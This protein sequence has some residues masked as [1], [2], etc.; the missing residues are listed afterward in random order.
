M[1][2]LTLA[3]TIQRLCYARLR[4]SSEK[5]PAAMFREMR[6]GIIRR[7]HASNLHENQQM[8]PVSTPQ[9]KRILYRSKQVIIEVS[10]GVYTS[11][12]ISG[13]RTFSRSVVRKR[14]QIGS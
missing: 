2:Q 1:A 3:R 9:Q 12:V 7:F 13:K 8:N 4:L 6:L 10:R 5:L 14:L 11:L